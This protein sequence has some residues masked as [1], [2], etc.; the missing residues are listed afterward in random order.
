MATSTVPAFKKAFVAAVDAALPNVE[1]FYGWPDT[2]SP[3]EVV[4]VG[5][6]RFAGEWA[7][8]ARTTKPRAEDYQ[9]DLIV[10]VAPPRA[11]AEDAADRA[12]QI[13][14][15]IEDVLR[16]SA[17]PNGLVG[18]GVTGVWQCEFRT[19]EE[20]LGFLRD[21]EGHVIGRVCRIT[22]GVRVQARIKL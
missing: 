10:E 8:I 3:D 6:T 20:E 7:A 19:A 11:S 9:F 22:A 15:T 4:Y 13:L 16:N 21:G 17:D 12:W 1:V 2:S 14:G 18:L 5:D